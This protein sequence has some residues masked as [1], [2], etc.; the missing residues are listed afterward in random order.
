MEES[1]RERV[2]TTFV[3]HLGVTVMLDPGHFFTDHWDAATTAPYDWKGSCARFAEAADPAAAPGG[4]PLYDF[5]WIDAVLAQPFVAQAGGKIVLRVMETYASASRVPAWM[6]AEGYAQQLGGAGW[7]FSQMQD[8]AVIYLWQDVVAAFAQRYAGDERIASFVFDETF[9][10]LWDNVA[11]CGNVHGLNPPRA[12]NAGLMEVAAAYLAED[13]TQLFTFVNWFAAESPP[14][15]A[16]NQGYDLGNGQR[17]L[18]ADDLPGAQ[19]HWRQ[20]MKFFQ[21]GGSGAPCTVDAAEAEY[22]NYYLAQHAAIHGTGPVFVGAEA[23][24]WW[25]AETTGHRTGSDNPWNVDPWPDWSPAGTLPND[26]GNLFPSARFWVWYTSGPPR[27]ELAADRDSGLGQSGS[28]PCGVV[29]ATFYVPDTPYDDPSHPAWTP[30][31]LSAAKFREAFDTFGP[32]GTKAMF[33]HPPGYL[34]QFE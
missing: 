28:D 4:E 9:P 19:G 1:Y 2:G 29:P 33:H 7:W 10:A 30:D 22:M 12:A 17:S 8:W 31:N 11:L 26:D 14:L 27:A 32:R 23:N 18:G 25:I 16:F 21:D 34:T 13:P 20:D 5:A 6:K 15:D 24:G 3:S